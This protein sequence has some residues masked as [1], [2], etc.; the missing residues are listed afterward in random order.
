MEIIPEGNN[1]KNMKNYLK[2]DERLDDLQRD[3]LQIIQHPDKFCFGMDAVLLS[4]FS[5][6]KKNSYVLDLGTGTGILPLLLSS[7]TE[8]KH[9]DALEIQDESVD[10]AN[11]SIALNHLSDKITVTQGDIK[12]ASS[13]YGKQVFDAVVT[14]P[15]YMN[16]KHGLKN[17][18]LPKAIARH[19]IHCTLQDVI[20][21]ASIVLK[22][23]HSLYMVHRP[24]RLPEIFQQ[25]HTYKLEPKRMC[26]VQPYIDKEPNMVLI[27]AVKDGN[28]MLK[29]EPP[30][31]VYHKNGEYTEQLKDIYYQ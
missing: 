2:P 5:T 18:D 27:E 21:E 6:I 10:M 22:P 12:K 11:R 8:A 28:P 25:M 19:E 17:P 23:K 4:H 7:L 26:L 24:F 16:D 3:G 13:I 31:I 15:P 9:F 1:L 14:N 29:I 20:R 30:I